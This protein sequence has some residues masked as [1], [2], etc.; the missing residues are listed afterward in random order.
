MGYCLSVV[1]SIT[2][3]PHLAID[4]VTGPAVCVKAR[5]LLNLYQASA[6]FENLVFVL[7]EVVVSPLPRSG[8]LAG[9]ILWLLQRTLV[10]MRLALM[11][12]APLRLVHGLA[13]GALG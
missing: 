7:V 1:V 2:T 8:H 12:G 3:Q 5:M 9:P 11:V 4:L 10:R 13:I 6:A